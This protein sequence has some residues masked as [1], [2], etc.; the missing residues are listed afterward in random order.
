MSMMTTTIRGTVSS[1]AKTKDLLRDI[2]IVSGLIYIANQYGDIPGDLE[3]Q[4]Q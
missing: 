2:A 4:L 1:I 3:K